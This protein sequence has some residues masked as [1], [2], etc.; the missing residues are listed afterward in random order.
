LREDISLLNAEAA[1]PPSDASVEKLIKGFI[2]EIP[3]E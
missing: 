3:I 2:K 1:P